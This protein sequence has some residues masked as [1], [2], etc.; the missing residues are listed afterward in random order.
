MSTKEHAMLSKVQE[1]KDC[2]ITSLFK[3]K[4]K[5]QG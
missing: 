4:F 1:Q 5:W 3:K 2:A